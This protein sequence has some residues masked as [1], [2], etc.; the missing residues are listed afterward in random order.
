VASFHV[1]LRN[2]PLIGDPLLIQEVRGDGL[3][4]KRVTDVLLVAQDFLER[5]RQPVFVASGCPDAVSGKL[6]PDLVVA[7]KRVPG[8][9][10]SCL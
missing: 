2:D 6:L 10:N 8:T 4:Q 1:I 7:L 9:I 3:L 5:A